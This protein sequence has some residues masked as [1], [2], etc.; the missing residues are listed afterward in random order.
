MGSDKALLEV[1]G[2]ALA[3]VAADALHDAGAAEVFAVGGDARALEG[4]GLTTVADRWP[5][6][7]PLGGLV[8]AIAAASNDLVVV[9]SCDLPSVGAEAVAEVLDALGDAD[10]ALPTVDGRAQL[11]LGAWRRARCLPVLHAAFDHGERAIWRAVSALA[12][13][14]VTLSVASWAQDADDATGLFRRDS[15]G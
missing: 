12:V 9:L 7:G 10:A 5:G 14:E 1:D 3:R 8:T 2:R 6:E 11:L 4:L 15:P 13:T